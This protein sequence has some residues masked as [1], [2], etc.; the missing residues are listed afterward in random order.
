LS[1]GVE[2]LISVL[3]EF[4]PEAIRRRTE[5]AVREALV[6]F[7]ADEARVAVKVVYRIERVGSAAK[8]KLVVKLTHS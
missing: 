3:P 8:E 2:V 6:K 5:D 7:D 4:N 1:D